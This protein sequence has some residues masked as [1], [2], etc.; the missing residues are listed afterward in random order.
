MKIASLLVLHLISFNLC[1]A[2]SKE[3]V[4]E[5]YFAA[6][7]GRDAWK[8]IVT[9]KKT[10]MMT[11]QAIQINPLVPASSGEVS[12][13]FEYLHK[14][15]GK[16]QVTMHQ[17]SA[18]SI[19]SYDGDQMWVKIGTREATPLPKEHADYFLAISMIGPG[20]LFID[21]AASI[22]YRGRKQIN[23]SEYEVLEIKR[24][25]WVISH[26]YMFDPDSGLLICGMA[27]L[28][29]AKR[30]TYFNEYK[31]FGDILMYTIEQVF[32]NGEEE[33][34]ARTTAIVFNEPINDS[35]FEMHP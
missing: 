13:K 8:R 25:E 6:I 27:P 12:Y 28:S 20:D 14:R 1:S 35:M 3:V 26:D 10:A 23:G 16:V 18:R 11:K 17:D 15:P 4:I 21:E 9:M 31:K 33:S 34:V 5:K 24:P 2:Q 30:I 7:G 29:Q 19:M 22:I 32:L